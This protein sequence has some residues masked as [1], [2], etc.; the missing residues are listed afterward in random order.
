VS[1][2]VTV[3]GLKAISGG[4]LFS[5]SSLIT[6]EKSSATVNLG[7]LGRVELAPNSNLRLSFSDN[8]I[9]ASL[10]NGSASVSTLA[11]VS[12]SLTTSD[13]QVV[14]N[15]SKATSFTVIT[16][17]GNTALATQSGLAEL[18]TGGS[19][20]MVAAGENATTGTTNP[21]PQTGTEE[22]G[23][24]GGAL[25]VLLLAVGG[26]IAAVVYATTSNNDLNFGGTVN[27]VSPSK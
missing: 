19:V 17:A 15:G 5:D 23:L 27:V 18:R 14:V 25:A 22:G 8:S 21:L 26:A 4:T 13:G 3:N 11:G 7:K 1:G 10:E 9:N 20:K 16:E 24:S 12:V 2:N 6:A